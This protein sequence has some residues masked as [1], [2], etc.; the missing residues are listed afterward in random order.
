MKIHL[1]I[2]AMLVL[3]CIITQAKKPLTTKEFNQ[4][5][6]LPDAQGNTSNIKADAKGLIIIFTCNHCPFASLYT[7]RLNNLH[8]KYAPLGVPVIAI[9]SMDTLLYEDETFAFMQAKVREENYAFPYLQDA[10]QEWGWRLDAVSTPSAFV[11]WKQ[12]DGWHIKYSGLIDD[13]G[14][15]PELAKSYVGKAVDE[16]LQNQKVSNPK[17]KAFGCAIGYGRNKEKLE[18]INW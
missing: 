12:K 4:I 6:Q 5:L 8:K 2:I 10:G 18:S 14:K 1:S 7:Q 17:T 9:N 3:G 13:N 16:L 11:L 15:H